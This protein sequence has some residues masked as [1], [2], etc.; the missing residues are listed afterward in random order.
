MKNPFADL[1]LNVGIVL[2]VTGAVICVITA[3]LAWS[4]WNRWSGISAITT[5][6]IRMLDSHDAV[7]KTRSAHAARLLP[8]E[9]V[10]VL[11]DT[12][13]SS[14]SDHKRL[15]SLEHHVSGSERELVQTSQALMLALRGKE[16]THHVSGSD[17]VLIAAL[18]HLNKS[19][20][21]Y[22]IALEKNAPPHH[23]VMAYVYAKQLRAA[24]ETG[25][26]DLIRGAACA[27][28]MLLP[29]HADGNALRYITTILDP[30]SNLIALNRAAASVPI[31][32]LKLLSNAMA[33]IVP[34]RASQLTAIGLGVPSDT[35][36]AQ[37]LPAQVAA[38]I[39]QDGDV[40]RVA[41]VRRCLDAGRYDLA[42]NLLPKM[43]PDRQ[44]ELRNIIMNQEG[45]LPE[46]LKA[47]A[48][49][50]ALM[51]RM[52]NLRT[53]IGFV[54]FHIS[55]DLGMVPKT[56]IQVRFNGSDIE[57]SAVRQNGSLFSVTIE[58]KHSAQATLEV[59][60]GKDVLAT[61]QVSL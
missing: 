51:P 36:A 9:A 11:L 39:A 17:G 28:A 47:G 21:P 41:L 5:A 29:A 33:L 30:G 40:D 16:P 23:A 61:K 18:V 14:E 8:K 52:S 60:V 53:R 57:P 13:L 44:T 20:R 43:P 37:L 35:P 3:A 24:I 48:T 19:G 22:A 12:D 50:P 45:N 32:Q 42:K 34:E 2:A 4:S 46:L 54:G 26:R 56:G 10:A 58:S 55:N 27:L 1:N 59:L 49:D 31:P 7:V 15:E 25:D 6:R 38:A